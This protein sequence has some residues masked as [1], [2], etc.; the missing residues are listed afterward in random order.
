MIFHTTRQR[1]SYYLPLLFT[2]GVVDLVLKKDI[3]V[4]FPK[5]VNNKHTHNLFEIEWQENKQHI[6]I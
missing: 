3:L 5:I 6:D 4:N 2:F 1:R